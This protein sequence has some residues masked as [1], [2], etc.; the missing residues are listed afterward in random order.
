MNSAD[1]GYLELCRDNQLWCLES[2]QHVNPHKG[3]DGHEDG[4][5][6]DELPQLA[7]PADTQRNS[8]ILVPCF[9]TLSYRMGVITLVGK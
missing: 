4:E 6:A 8:V 9:Q 3:H 7:P 1:S 5:V 2:Q